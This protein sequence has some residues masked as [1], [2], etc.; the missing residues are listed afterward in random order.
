MV[1]W[2]QKFH[3]SLNWSSKWVNV[4]LSDLSKQRE[5]VMNR[6]ISERDQTFCDSH[7]NNESPVDSGLMI[8]Q[9]RYFHL[10]VHAQVQ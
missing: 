1:M 4:S 9:Y 7:F 6:D 5:T 10:L 8:A 3:Q 2:I